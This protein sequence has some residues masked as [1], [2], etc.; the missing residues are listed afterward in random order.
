MSTNSPL[1]K[2]DSPAGHRVKRRCFE[3]DR[4]A[5]APCVWCH[6]PIDYALGPYS[7]GG[8]TW[9][10]SPEHVKPRDKYPELA[11]DPANIV[12]AHFHCNA[13]RRDRAGMTNLGKPSREW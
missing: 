6:A 2:W 8:D 4:R 7:R 3:R 5:N 13:K 10:W 9:A 12:A 1:D 11:L